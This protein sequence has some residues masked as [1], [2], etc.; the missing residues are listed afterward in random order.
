[1]NEDAGAA[2]VREAPTGFEHDV[3]RIA[4]A[5]DPDAAFQH[6]HHAVGPREPEGAMAGE[7]PA[8]GCRESTRRSWNEHAGQVLKDDR[9]RVKRCLHG[10]LL[11]G[12]ASVRTVV[13][14]SQ[15]AHYGTGAA[16]LRYRYRSDLR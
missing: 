1:M 3:L 4:V 14:L 12:G 6:V 11:G 2:L 16:R 8:A 15:S 13:V 9:E 7:V 5:R 10:R